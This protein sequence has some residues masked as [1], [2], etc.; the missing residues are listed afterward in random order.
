MY[1]RVEPPNVKNDAHMNDIGK[2]KSQLT[3]DRDIKC[4]SVYG[5][6]ILHV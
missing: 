1:A 4:L 5:K 2:S 6:G 3:H